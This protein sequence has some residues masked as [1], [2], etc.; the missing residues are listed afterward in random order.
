MTRIVMLGVVLCLLL[1]SYGFAQLD[2][3]EEVSKYMAGLESASR[4]QRV[5]SAKL[6]SRSGLQDRIL[7][8]KIADLLKAGYLRE[9]EKDHTDEMSW[10]CKALAASGDPQYRELLGEIAAKSPSMKLQRY[11]KQSSELIDQNAQ[12]SRILNATEAWDAELST[13]ENRLVSMLKSADIGLRRDAAKIIIRNLDSDE[14]VFA[15][16]ASALSDMSNKSHPDSSYVDT[17][18]WLCKC[19]AASGDGQY[20]GVLEQVHGN[21]QSLKLRTYASKA[22]KV[23]K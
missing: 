20:I 11:A 22:I 8:L 21:T 12:R 9:Y 18:S 4:V 15:A 14:K 17:M 7:Y 5:N 19:L 10:L 13:E 2:R 23:L 1:P 6:I 16:A 3:S